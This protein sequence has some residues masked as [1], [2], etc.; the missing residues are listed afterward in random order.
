MEGELNAHNMALYPGNEIQKAYTVVA[1]FLLCFSVLVGSII[2]IIRSFRHFSLNCH[3]QSKLLS[4]VITSI[5]YARWSNLH[6]EGG[7][8]VSISG[9]ICYRPRLVNVSMVTGWTGL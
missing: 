1:G 9:E 7:S 4:Q 5:L 8:L 6:R 2:R 3:S